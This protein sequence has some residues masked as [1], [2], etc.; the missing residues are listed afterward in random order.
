MTEVNDLL[1]SIG[2]AGAP[3]SFEVINVQN[4]TSWIKKELPFSISHHCSTKINE[5]TILI[6]GGV[7]GGKV[8]E[9]F[10][11]NITQKIYSFDLKSLILWLDF[12]LFKLIRYPFLFD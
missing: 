9:K 3:P 8:S 10:K 12:E 5:T 4:G 2:G 11:V 7:S 6:T 1:V